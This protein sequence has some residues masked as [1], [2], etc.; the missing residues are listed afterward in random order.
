MII[1][2]AILSSRRRVPCRRCS[3]LAIRDRTTAFSALA[4][5]TRGSQMVQTG[6]DPERIWSARVTASLLDV[7]GIRP[8][9]GE[10]F[11]AAHELAGNDRVA[12][13]SHGLWLR[14]FG[15]DAGVLGRTLPVAGGP[16]VVLGVMPEGFS[17]PVFEDRL[18]DVWTPYVIPEQERQTKQQSAY[19]HVVGR[20]RAGATLVEAQAQTDD[21]RKSLAA[22]DADRYP[23]GGRFTV[24]TLED[25]VVGPVRGSMVL[26]LGA[27]GLLL[28]VACANVA[29]LLLTRAIDRARD[30]S[31]RS[32]LGA[33]RRRL[34]TSLL[35]E[36]LLLLRS[37]CGSRSAPPCR[38]LSA[39]YSVRWPA[40][41]RSGWRWG[42]RPHGS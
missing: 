12:V 10:T 4:A 1:T 35:I 40:T 22:A 3:N 24:R 30:L 23:P 38:R 8:L 31:I 18:A 21:V 7:L 39:R 2:V 32:A 34:V 20:L 5:V 29:N 42:F 28:V 6:G 19:L 26:V 33:T 27:V 41:W 17:Y 36:S 14:H 9:F 15:G 11:T 37:A 13:I 25:A 16:L